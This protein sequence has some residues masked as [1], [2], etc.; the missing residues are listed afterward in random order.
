MATD[1]FPFALYVEGQWDP[2]TSKLKNK[3]II[4][5]QSS[6][7]SDGGD[8]EVEYP[9]S[10]GQTATVR[11]K[12]KEVRQRVLNKQ[13]HELN[14]GQKTVKITVNLPPSEASV[15]QES[16][17]STSI[18]TAGEPQSGEEK[19]EKVEP[20]EE[21]EEDTTPRSAVIENIQNS[22]QEFLTMLVENILKGSSAESKDFNIEII[23]ESNCA[24]VAFSN[25]KYVQRVLKEQHQLKKQPF[26]VL[27][28]YE[29]LQT[30]LYGK[31][32]PTLRLPEA[33]IEKIDRAVWHHLKENQ[34]SM[35]SIKQAMS[36]HF[37]EMDFQSSAVKISPS[38]SL[39]NNGVQTRKLIQTWRENVLSVFLSLTSEF[40]STEF[41]IQKDAWTEI[42][43]E[44]QKAVVGEAV[45]LVPNVDEGTITV[46]GLKEDMNRIGGILTETV[47]RVTQRIQ[48]EKGSETGETSMTPSIY[49]LV[50][51][52]GLEQQ[53]CDKFPEMNITYHVHS[54]KLT[55][56]G[57]K[58]EV[59]ETKNKILQAVLNLI[60]KPIELH[61]SVL[62]FLLTKD[63]EEMTDNLFLN[64]GIN[65]ALEAD[66]K[67]V[68]LVG[69][70]DNALSV[71]EKQLQT[72]L[73]HLSFSV[74]DPS[75]LGRSDWHDLVSHIKNTVTNVTVQTTVNQVVVSG[76]VDSITDVEQE[77]HNFVQ[78]NSQFEKTLKSHKT[79]VTFIKNHKKQDWFEEVKGNVNVDF[80]GEDIVISG[81]RLHVSKCVL[82]FEDLLRSV[83][84]CTMKI[85]KPGAK[86]FFKEKELMCVTYVQTNMN[87]LVQLLDEYDHPHDTVQSLI[88]KPVYHYKTHEGME[89]TVNKADMCSFQV[90]AVVG[91]CKENLLLDG[92]LVK[93]LSDAAGPKLQNDCNQ[94]VKKRKLTTG[95]AVLLDAG[96]R[97]R[98]KHVI[99]AIGPN[100]NIYKPQESE[101]LL[102][103]TVKK[104]LNLADQESFQSLAIPAISS[105]VSGGGFPLDLCAD[106]I[107]KA[108]KEFC[109]FVEEDNT[110]KKIHLVDNNDKTV[111][112]LEAAVKKIY[113]VSALTHSMAS[114]SSSSSQQQNQNQAS[115]SPSQ[116]QTATLFQGASQS[117]QTKEGLTITLMK[118]NIE[119]TTMDVVVN[120]LSSDLNLS[121]GAISNALLKAAGPQLQ[122]LLNQQVT[123]SANIGAVFETAGA[124]L[125]NKLVFHAVV[126]HWNQGQGNEQ[127]VLEDIMDKCL[128]LAEQRQQSSILFSAIGTGNLGFPKPLVVCTMLDSAFKFSSKRSSK[129]VKDVVFVLHPKDTQTI[130]VFTDEFTK[131]FLGQSASASN[132][133]QPQSTG[134]FSKVITKSGIHETTVGGVTLQVLNG[135]ITLEKTDVIVNSS[136]KE[137]TLKA[138]VSKAILDKAGPNVE[139]ECQ[140]LG[141]QDKSGLIMTQAGNL[142]CKKIIHISVQSNAGMIQS[143]VKKALEM[144]AKE[145][146]TS[147]AFPAIGTGKAGLSPGQVADCM[148][149]GIL[150][151]IRKTPQSTLKLIR[152]VVFQA[153]MLPE[154]HKSMQN[155]ETGPAKQEQSTWS[156]IKAYAA[157][158]KSFFTGSW[159]KEIKQHGGKDFVIEGVQVDPVFFSICG[160]SQADVDETKRFL[161]GMIDQ[162]QVFEAITDTAIL[163][164]SDK[165]QQRIQDLQSTI[166]VTIRLEYKANKGSEETP[167]QATLIIQGLSRDVLK[168]IQEIQDMLKAA[169]EK[170][171]LQKEMDYT[172][173]LVDWQYEQGGQFRNFDQRTNFE[174]EKAL[175]KQAAGIRISFQGQTYQVTLPEGPAV[176][177]TGGNQM[178][179]RRIDKLK[180]TEDIP[181][182][183]DGMAHNEL[184][185]KFNLQPTSTEYKEVNGLFQATCPS[186][187]VLKIERIQNPG[188]WRNY[189]NNKSVMEKKNGHQKNEKRLFHGT[190]EQTISHIEKSGFN[191][192]YAGK[193]A[194]AYGKGTYFALN[195]RY[196]SNNT[197]SVPNAQGHKHM[198]LCRVL[199]GDYT[200]GNSTMF[201]P[202]AKNANFD[203]YDTVVDN[204]NAPTIFVVFRDDNAYPEYLI[205][206]T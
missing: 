42:Q 58:H 132:P 6:K 47:E 157:N 123:G 94:T 105:G 85:V 50:L 54:R 38:Q 163:T 66:G 72:D 57:L 169:K 81:S 86:K 52:D 69:K 187:K 160:P 44:I 184:C 174:L 40:K 18:I 204:P 202:P 41:C 103:K 200:T 96:G 122:V 101:K 143:H 28:Y 14:I 48:R 171:T 11:F 107:V 165:D 91:G 138:G 80:K 175:G 46:A 79:V 125:K 106:T 142:Q 109:D 49:N 179:I 36:S 83:H 34:K 114:G 70:T 51:R 39:L 134:P 201:V 188:M 173:E 9:V 71:G 178:K 148:L 133:T 158:V 176:C 95:D 75:V 120:T 5:F 30:A 23:P 111:Q 65:V 121:V 24:V 63:V 151:M 127:K 118:G 193:N 84:N 88:I 33:F 15:P 205:T 181:Q 197:Y 195:A 162:E 167:G 108:I 177:T 93:V 180:A 27:P 182:Y 147:I 89:I 203:Q 45:T 78:E 22:G 124:N 74:E 190:S 31:D 130:Q 126:P 189:Q 64:K 97:L 152:L 60:H 135:D 149:D 156:K 67:R 131:R 29:T 82:L 104:S 77:L 144:C 150:D 100:Y 99:L 16:T 117:F 43:P 136:N 12:S 92:G 17:S 168:A 140:Q 166:D 10:G 113:G 128:S 4:Y 159:E 154:F 55:F 199:T 25:S 170:E 68:L 145:K 192:S 59:L 90:D 2:L 37:C 119:D 53:I 191:R 32:R 186:N 194:T 161:E 8:C 198:Y 110:L 137:F 62:D 206:F 185:R 153:Q 139:A 164:L 7:K 35:D 183:W 20:L 26:R 129:H 87:C 196:S 19:E 115:S 76:F 112:A 141:A 116:H 73:G 102:K 146:L 61:Q 1:E 56:Y 98:C 155:Q 21:T 172:S 3:L 13:T